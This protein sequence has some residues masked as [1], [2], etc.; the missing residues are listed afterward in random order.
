[1]T[2]GRPIPF[3]MPIALAW[4]LAAGLVVWACG[5]WPTWRIAG[6]D[7]VRAQAA[8][9]ATVTAVMI[10]TT[11][12]MRGCAAFGPVLTASA[13]VVLGIARIALCLGLIVCIRTFLNLPPAALLL[14]AALFYVPM[15]LVEGVYLAYVLRAH[16]ESAGKDSRWASP[17][18]GGAAC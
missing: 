12:V 2:P 5:V 3:R 6:A 4:V 9:G 17:Q 11:V 13:F 10:A 15:L 8:A 18:E 1:M 16:G 14:W 7:A